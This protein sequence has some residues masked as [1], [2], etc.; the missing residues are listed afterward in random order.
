MVKIKLYFYLDCQHQLNCCIL[1][2]VSQSIVTDS[3]NWCCLCNSGACCWMGGEIRMNIN[4]PSF[5]YVLWLVLIT[6][7]SPMEGTDLYM[8]LWTLYVNDLG[9]WFSTSLWQRQMYFINLTFIS[10]WPFYSK[11]EIYVV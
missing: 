2:T 1:F 6:G 8:T 4:S 3:T 7:S 11:K 5:A 9:R 10:Y